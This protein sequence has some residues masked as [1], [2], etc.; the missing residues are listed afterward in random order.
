MKRG[1]LLLACALYGYTA[2][3]KKEMVRLENERKFSRR[4]FYRLGELFAF[5]PLTNGALLR[6]NKYTNKSEERY[7]NRK[8]ISRM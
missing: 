4:I 2:F 3:L 8:I 1:V 5:E 7:G 6:Y